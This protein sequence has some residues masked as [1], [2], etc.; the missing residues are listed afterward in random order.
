[1]TRTIVTVYERILVPTDGSPTSE[2]AL[3]HA[4]D[5]TA[6]LGAD[7][8][9]VTVLDVATYAGLPMETAWEGID[10]V[11]RSDARAALTDAQRVLE[12]RGVASETHLLEGE[13]T[14]EI[15]RFAERADCDLIVMG[16]RGRGGIDRL[17]LGSVAEAVVRSADVPVTT[18]RNADGE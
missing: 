6:A 3:R 9:V 14:R 4:A 18:V 5:L 1:M 10:D 11:L 15:V 13:P 12:G 2:R 17:L 7:L 8:L 16:T